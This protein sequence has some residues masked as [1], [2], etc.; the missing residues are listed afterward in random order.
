M[1]GLQHRCW[2]HSNTTQVLHRYQWVLNN[3]STSESE[4]AAVPTCLVPVSQ[5]K[6]DKY[7]KEHWNPMITCHFTG[8]SGALGAWLDRDN[9]I[10]QSPSHLS[11][12]ATPFLTH[13]ETPL[14]ASK[15]SMPSWV[16]G[17]QATSSHPTPTSQ[18]SIT[19]SRCAQ[20]LRGLCLLL[21][22]GCLHPHRSPRSPTGG[23]RRVLCTSHCEAPVCVWVAGEVGARAQVEVP[24]LHGRAPSTD[25]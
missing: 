9:I 21:W 16:S 14:V 22:P 11:S 19:C 5:S 10:S 7:H 18:A 25:P 1:E 17:Q 3:A 13:A 2:A 12:P 23:W 15:F 20:R 6:S 24:G 4:Q 8:K